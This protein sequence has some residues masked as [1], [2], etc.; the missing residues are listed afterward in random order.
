MFVSILVPHRPLS[1]EA[2]STGLNTP[3]EPFFPHRRP[4]PPS[5]SPGNFPSATSLPASIGVGI[6]L[7]DGSPH[8]KSTQACNPFSLLLQILVLAV[9]LKSGSRIGSQPFW[10]WRAIYFLCRLLECWTRVLING[11]RGRVARQVARCRAACPQ[12]G[13]VRKEEENER[14]KK[15]CQIDRLRVKTGP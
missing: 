8:A 14:L 2:V 1:R 15:T 5:L 10:F 3:S 9:R 7:V 12:E 13:R 11:G 4:V 6:R